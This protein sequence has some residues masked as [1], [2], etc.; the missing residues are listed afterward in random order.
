M[1]FGLTNAPATF[2][3]LMNDIFRDMLDECVIIYLDDILIYS[4]TPEEHQVHLERVLQRLQEHRLYAKPSKCNFNMTEIKYLGFLITPEG[5]K[6]DP[7][8]IRAIQEFPI[9]KT[10]KRL[11]SFLGLANYYRKFVENYSRIA[12]PLT[13]ALQHAS[14]SKPLSWTVERNAAFIE[15]KQALT[16]EPCLQLPDPH[17]EFEVTTDAAEETKTVGAVLTQN[18]HPIAFESR[19]LDKH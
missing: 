15:L 10:L 19:K 6:P 13:D 16:S 18:G 7:D 11:Q 8:L 2:Q 3:S 14:N 9:P 1:P 5:I 17:G 12:K 4:K